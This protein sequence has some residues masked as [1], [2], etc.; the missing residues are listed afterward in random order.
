[1][2]LIVVLLLVGIVT[3]NCLPQR[4]GGKRGRQGRGGEPCKDN[5]GI[6]AC[7]CKD[8]ST[9]NSLEACKEICDK[10]NNPIVSCTCVDGGNWT[11][12]EKPASSEESEESE[13]SE[14]SEEED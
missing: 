7:E 2:K 10:K 1:M 12:P 13:E 5:E 6:D 3:V 14:V 9:C 4:R 11:K 8:K